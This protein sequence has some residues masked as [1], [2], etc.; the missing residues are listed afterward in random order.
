MVRK[1]W[2]NK[3]KLLPAIINQEAFHKLDDNK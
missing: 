1:M 3:K 2:N